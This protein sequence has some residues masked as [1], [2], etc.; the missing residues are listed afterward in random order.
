M[1]VP[2]KSTLTRIKICGVRNPAEARA[3]LDAGADAVGVVVSESPRRVHP[4]EAMAIAS[5]CPERTVLVLRG[6][7]TQHIDLLRSWPG[8]VQIHDPS[9]VP[10]RRCILGLHAGSPPPADAWFE[11]ASAVLLDGS[12]AGSGQPWDW[13]QAAGS[14]RG[15]PRILAG[16]LRPDN[17]A[18]AIEAVRPWAVDVSSGVEHARGTKD[19]ALVRAFIAAVRACDQAAAR[20]ADP[21]PPD[22]AALA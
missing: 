5:A 22:F 11:A 18:A 1:T 6:T 16:G 21:W 4:A 10:P 19:L 14:I 7:D 9:G 8:P 15:L 13:A 12:R 20:S 17:V 3:V 2:E